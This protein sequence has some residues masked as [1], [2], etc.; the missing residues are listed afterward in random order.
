MANKT[1]YEILKNI[2]K[3]DPTFASF[4]SDWTKETFTEKGFE[5]IQYDNTKILDDYFD[6]SVRVVLNLVEGN[7]A[8]D[9]LENQGFSKSYNNP[10]GDI[11]Q[12]IQIN[13]IKPINPQFK[14]L[15]N[16]GSVDPY[17][18]R[19]PET[20][21]RFFKSNF[22]YQ[23]LI[24]IQED[25]ARKIFISETGMY[26]FISGILQ[27]LNSAYEVQKYVAKLE[28][29][30]SGINSTL[31]PLQDSQ[32]IKIDFDEV[33][34][35]EQLINFI[36]KIKNLISDMRV[37]PTTNK[38][39][40]LRFSRK[41]NIN[42]LSLLVRP[43]IF[44]TLDTK[45]L[46]FA[47]NPE[48]L[49]LNLNIVQVENFGGVYYINKDNQEKLSPVYDELGICIGYN[50]TGTGEPLNADEIEAV[51]PNK[52]ILGIVAD[53]GY[54]FTTEQ[55]QYVVKTIDNP[56]GLYRNYWASKMNGGVYVDNAYTLVAIYKNTDEVVETKKT[57]KKASST[58]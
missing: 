30:N 21:E 6:L 22:N 53:N 14:K 43:E 32:K 23:N 25:E 51:D 41:Q 4:T 56:A 13:E 38:Y 17:K 50:T 49:K 20:N 48:R 29:L 26:D 33:A 39:N 12:R 40:A 47:F 18:I 45:V 24:T 35:N 44:N 55:N 54:I 34:T 5:A 2:Q 1:N 58:K 37:R 11:L 10:Y 3:L 52:N 42:D 9:T 57:I 16:Y 15:V 19:K 31:Y 27:N 46:S 36:L 7:N 8:I 28:A